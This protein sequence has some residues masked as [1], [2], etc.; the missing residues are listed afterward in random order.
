MVVQK[1]NDEKVIETESLENRERD[2]RFARIDEETMK[3]I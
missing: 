3:E 1:A 2:Q